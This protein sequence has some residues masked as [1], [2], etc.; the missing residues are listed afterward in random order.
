MGTFA[1]NE[2]LTDAEL[3]RLGD[4]LASCR[5]EKAMTLQ[6]LDWFFAAPLIAGPEPVMPSEYHRE[7]FG[8]EM[9]ETCESK[10]IEEANEILGLMMRFWNCVAPN[11][12]AGRLRQVL[13]H[14]GAVFKLVSIA[15]AE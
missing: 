6:E 10:D 7:V 8:G 15:F 2:P 5:S 3:D 4:F 12:Y 14:A 13:Q 9:G 1:D 11:S